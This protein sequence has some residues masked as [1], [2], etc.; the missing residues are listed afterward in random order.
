[1][2][3][4][5]WRCDA[6][7]Y[8]YSVPRHILVRV[9]ISLFC[10]AFKHCL[11]LPFLIL[12]T[13]VYSIQFNSFCSRN[14]HLV[15]QPLDIEQVIVSGMHDY[16]IAECSSLTAVIL[17]IQFTASW[18][19]NKRMFMQNISYRSIWVL[20]LNITLP[21]QPVLH[22]GFLFSLLFD[23]EVGGDIFRWNINWHSLDYIVS[24]HRWQHFS[25]PWLW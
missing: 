15:I 12:S 19:T 8:R 4:G 16:Q 20:S 14:P 9:K 25:K 7:S 17:L 13:L 2:Y 5:E 3:W 6:R 24:Y 21:M 22:A 23:L 18:K 11:I 1:M 10:Q